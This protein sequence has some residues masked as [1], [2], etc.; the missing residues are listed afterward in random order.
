MVNSEITKVAL[1]LGK[2]LAESG[3]SAAEEPE[4]VGPE[5]NG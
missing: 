5:R 4:E 1:W 2:K 3:F